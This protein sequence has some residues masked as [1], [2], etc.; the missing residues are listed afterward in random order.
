MQAAGTQLFVAMAPSWWRGVKIYSMLKNYWRIAWRTITRNKV[1]T[2]INVLGLA[3][4]ICGCLVLY[5]I[6][7]YELSFDRQ[8][9]D[10]DRIYRIVGN[11]HRPDGEEAFMNSPYDDVA[12]FETQIPG[13]EAKAAVFGFGAKITVPQQGA[14]AKEFENRLGDMYQHTAVVTSA[15]YF[16]IFKY[17]W[18]AG[19]AATLDQPNNVVLTESRGRLYFG[20]ISPA[21]MVGKTVVYDDSLPVHVSGIIKDL[22]GNSDLAY[23]DYVSVTT[24]THSF[25]RNDIPT[26]DWTSLRPHRS[27]AFVRLGKGVTPEQINQAFATYI[28]THVH[29]R[30]P[31]SSMVFYLQ[32]LRALHFTPEFHRGDDGDGWRK[33]YP[34]TVY[35]LIGVAIFILLIAAINFVN[36][37]TAQSM[38]RAKEVGVR[39]VMGGRKRN[40]REQFLIETL[41]VTVLAASV[42]VL[43]V[44]PILALFREYVPA[45]VHFQ[46]WSTGTLVFLGAVVLLTTL[47]AGFYPAWVMSRYAAVESLKGTVSGSSRGGLNMRRALI[48]FQFTISLVFIIG[49]IVIGKQIAFMKAADKGFNTERVLTLSDWGLTPQQLETYSKSIRH[50]RGVEAVI[51]QGTPPMGFAQN[52]DMF[53]AT[54]SVDALQNVSAHMGNEDYIPFYGMRLV[55]GRNIIHSDSLR[56][57]V[58]NETQAK[59]MGCKTPKEA[60]GRFLFAGASQG[61]IGKGYPVVGVVA[62]F[63]V[64]SFH[65]VIPP[66]VIENVRER[67]Q[68]IAVKLASAD[69]KAVKAVLAGMEKEWKQQFPDRWF[70]ANLLDE[71]I[72][73][74]FQQEEHTAW[75]TNMATGVTIFISCMGLFGLGLFTTRRRSK[76]ISIRKVLGASVGSITTL[77]SKDFAWL[78]GIAFVV[79]APVAW[80]FSHQWLQDF[81]YRTGLSWWVFVLAGVGAMGI[82]LLTVGLQAARSAMANP[83]EA[84]RSE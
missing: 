5:L 66:A 20:E 62:D 82:A 53:A 76:E 36:L 16:N 73:W 45:G 15:A 24:A 30:R 40:I 49:A 2:T 7:H 11:A 63:H 47:L 72:G 65:E 51:M 27:M 17:Q 32:P 42:A 35:A 50:I 39:K 67:Q 28:K 22:A 26:T 1:Y 21:E 44:N 55:A 77:L 46:P 18:L 52:M 64:G 48:V 19:N 9:P 34:P 68:S 58:I 14:P 83:A 6:T 81:A 31:G 78:V 75:L 29:L 38:S 25:L 71:S 12:G 61:G 23:T 54:P 13:F 57:L 79:S 3:L 41:L 60:L 33:V 69:P 43:L 37:S 80:W 74:L 8:H 84:L 59:R 56:E 10:G 70:S 4:G